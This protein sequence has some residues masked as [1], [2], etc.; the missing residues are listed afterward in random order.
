[1]ICATSPITASKVRRTNAKF[2]EVGKMHSYGAIFLDSFAA[3]RVGHF[4]NVARLLPGWRDKTVAAP[5]DIDNEPIP[6]TS[7]TQRAARCRN[8][9]SEGG[10]LDT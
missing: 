7:V 5:T 9:D 6:I 10:R 2:C 8:M 3:D 1:M 4:A